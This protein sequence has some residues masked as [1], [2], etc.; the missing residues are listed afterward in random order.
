MTDLERNDSDADRLVRMALSM[1]ALR[2]C[3]RHPHV[4]IATGVE[5]A[6]VP[7]DIADLAAAAPT[8]CDLCSE[9]D[10]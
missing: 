8:V 2:R 6:D 5:N 3:P 7:V 9:E 10:D 1:G 4:F